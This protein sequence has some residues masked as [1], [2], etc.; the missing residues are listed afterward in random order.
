M[1]ENLID[2]Y[3]FEIF[4]RAKIFEAE[5]KVFQAEQTLVMVSGFPNNERNVLLHK[6][7]VGGEKLKLEKLKSQIEEFRKQKQI[8]N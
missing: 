8:N 2:Q 3:A 6:S 4:S 5:F 7:L 1:D